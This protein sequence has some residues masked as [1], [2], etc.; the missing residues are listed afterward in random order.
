M[1]RFNPEYKTYKDLLNRGLVNQ[2]TQAGLEIVKSDVISWEF[3]QIVL[4][5]KTV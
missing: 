5:I 1:E 2:I 3:F 4:A